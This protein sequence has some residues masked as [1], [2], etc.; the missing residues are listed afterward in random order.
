MLRSHGEEGIEGKCRTVK[1]YD[2]RYRLNLL[3][4]SDEYSCAVCRTGV[5]NNSI[6]CSDSFTILGLWVLGL[7]V[8]HIN[9]S[10]CKPISP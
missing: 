6:Y 4:S 5:G 9:E 3:Q 7:A 2:L 10:S 1:V 8:S